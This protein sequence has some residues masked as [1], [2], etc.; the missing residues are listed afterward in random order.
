MP[1]NNNGGYDWFMKKILI[2]I[3]SLVI[4]VAPSVSVYATLEATQRETFA[5]NNILFYDPSETDCAATGANVSSIGDSDGSDVYMIGDSITV[6]SK[7]EIQDLMPK[8]TIDAISGTYFSQDVDAFGPG[9]VSRVSKM[10]NQSILLFAMGT[11]AGVNY[12]NKDDID[13]LFEAVSGKNIKIILMTI[14]YNGHSEEQMEESNKAVKEAAAQHD[15]VSY[16]DWYAAV[17]SDPAKYINGTDGIHPT[18]EAGQAKFAEVAKAAVDKVTTM[19]LKTITGSGDYTAIMNAKNAN[20]SVFNLPENNPGEWWAGWGD[21]DVE[22]MTRVLEHYGDLA[23]QTGRAI[24]VPWVGIIVQ[25]RYEDSRSVCG[26]NNFWGNGCDSNH[27]GYAGASFI[28]GKNLGEGFVQYAQTATNGYHDAA[29]GISDPAEFLDALAPTWIG[30]G[31]LYDM[32]NSVASMMAF[33]ETPEGQAIVSTFGNYSGGFSGRRF[34]KEGNENYAGNGVTITNWKGNTIAFPI[35][36]ATKKNISGQGFLSDIPCNSSVGCHYGPSNDPTAAAFDV[37]F[38]QSRDSSKSCVGATVVSMTSGTIT[39]EINVKRNEVDCGHVRVQSDYNDKV[40]A[41]MH[42]DYDADLSAKLPAGTHVE[43]GTVIGHVSGVGA[44]HDNSTPHVHIDM[45][46]KADQPGGPWPEERNPEI[47]T[48]MNAA[49]EVLPKDDAELRARESAGV[50]GEKGLTYEQAKKFVMN[51]GANKNGSSLAAVTDGLWGL[52]EYGNGRGWNGCAGGG[53][54]NCTAFSAFFLN[55]FTQTYVGG[56]TGDGG[57]VVDNLAAK[58]VPTGTEP[59]AWAV[60]SWAAA[61]KSGHTG[62]V[63]GYENGEWI[64]GQASCGSQKSG[65]GDGTDA[66]GGAAWA[67]KNED[68]GSMIWGSGKTIKYAYLGDQVDSAKVS[69][70]L[71]TGE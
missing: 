44:C 41:Y 57:E 13:K 38:D 49:Y 32:K 2:I 26:A 29:L 65:A 68:V 7:K 43:A 35:A 42:L 69:K 48:L 71:S 56:A 34:C 62:V 14:F 59:R 46:S 33:L 63:L 25:M 47:V 20:E 53:F 17:S 52:G 21:G 5:Q 10:G 54:S 50:S 66:G 27:S 9:G 30:T 64:V 8:I 16:M 15:N 3:I 58:G 60:F 4:T 23:Y 22:G 37:C 12:V 36:Y 28:Q 31:A 40:I 1:L 24:G 19:N 18:P 11:N 55:K 51:Y 70:F 6:N 45:S 61:G 39:Q 67:D